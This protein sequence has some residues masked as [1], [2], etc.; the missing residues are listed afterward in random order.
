MQSEKKEYKSKNIE[1]VS[2]VKK[3]GQFKNEDGIDIKYTTYKIKFK[4][5][6]NPLIYEAKVDRLFN[7]YMEQI[8]DDAD[9]IANSDNASADF[10]DEQ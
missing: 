3:K 4:H 6:D 9:A 8:L 2:I 10:W 1:I 7:E 5:K